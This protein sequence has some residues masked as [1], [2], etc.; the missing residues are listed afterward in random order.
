MKPRFGWIKDPSFHLIAVTAVLAGAVMTLNPT[1]WWSPRDTGIAHPSGC[2]VCSLCPPQVA[3][4]RDA[5]LIRSG[6][7]S[8]LDEVE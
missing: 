7:I 5:Y 6:G 1:S 2:H 4:A 8:P 3:A